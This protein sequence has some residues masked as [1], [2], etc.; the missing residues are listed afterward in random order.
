MIK[1]SLWL[2]EVDSKKLLGVQDELSKLGV[3]V[4]EKVIE[5]ELSKLKVK[6]ELFQLESI[7][8]MDGLLGATYVRGEQKG[9]KPKSVR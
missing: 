8:Q 3:R 2:L 4:V 5:T 1:K 7:L 6:A 9:R